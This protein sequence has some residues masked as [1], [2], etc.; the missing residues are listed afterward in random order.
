MVGADAAHPQPCTGW[1]WWGG[2][3]MNLFDV[4]RRERDGSGA[5]PWIGAQLLEAMRL[6][7]LSSWHLSSWH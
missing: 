2:G 4:K 6:L 1:E 3:R 7:H 5:H